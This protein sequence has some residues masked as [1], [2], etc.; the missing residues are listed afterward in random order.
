MNMLNSNMEIIIISK[1]LKRAL[2]E[3]ILDEE[4]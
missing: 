4:N 3:E 1:K 2:E